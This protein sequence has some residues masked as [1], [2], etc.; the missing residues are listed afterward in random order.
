MDIF[1]RFRRKVNG[2]EIASRHHIGKF[3]VVGTT[4]I[5]GKQV[6]R[7]IVLEGIIYPGYKLKGGGIALVREIRL[8]NRRVDF[9]VEHD[10]AALVLEGVL[11]VKEGDILEVYRS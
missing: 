3:K 5:P 1:K 10:E 7:G 8:Q 6:L 11:K 4:R 9:I 2:P